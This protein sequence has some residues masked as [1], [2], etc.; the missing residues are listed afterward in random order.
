MPKIFFE[1]I[2]SITLTSSKRF[3]AIPAIHFSE[4]SEHG[5]TQ[6]QGRVYYYE[7]ISRLS[8]YQA[9][10]IFPHFDLNG[11]VSFVGGTGFL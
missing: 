8:D 2:D 9:Y 6:K 11:S 4:L 1:V 5:E 7:N 10:R 3:A